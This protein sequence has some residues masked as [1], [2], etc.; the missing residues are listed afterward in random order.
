MAVVWGD[1]FSRK[2]H[3]VI[4][5]AGGFPATESWLNRNKCVDSNDRHAKAITLINAYMEFLDWNPENEFPEII[6]MDQERISALAA[7]ALRLCI[8]AS[9]VAIASSVPII[10]QQAAN[11]KAL[12]HQIDVLLQ[13]VNNNKYDFSKM[14]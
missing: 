10:G 11:R 9:A 3:F 13:S 7:R 12:S 1:F 2:I 8:C 14:Q 6:A 5:F 4:Y